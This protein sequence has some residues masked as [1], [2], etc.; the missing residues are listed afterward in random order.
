MYSCQVRIV[1][2]C[3]SVVDYYDQ[4]DFEEHCLIKEHC[5]IQEHYNALLGTW[6]IEE[7]NDDQMNDYMGKEERGLYKSVR[8]YNMLDHY[9]VLLSPY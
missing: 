4:E 7:Y 8:I 2:K 5:K 3:N 1:H 9:D 6:D